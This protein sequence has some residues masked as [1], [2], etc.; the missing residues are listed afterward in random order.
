MATDRKSIFITGAASGIGRATA[1]LFAER[2]WFVGL[3]DA[4]PVTE[5]EKDIPAERRVSGGFD[6]R[7][8]A[9]WA[10]AIATFGQATGG[11]LDVLFNNAGIAR[12]GRFDVVPAAD[13]ALTVDVNLKGVLNGIYA[14]LPL[15]KATPGARIINTASAASLY[16]TPRSAVYS[17]TKFAVRG[18]SQALDLE[19]RDYGVRCIAIA[20]WFID[21][22]LLDTPS[23][24]TNRAV[25]EVISGRMKVYPV[26]IVAEGVWRAA[27]GD[28]AF[29]PIGDAAKELDFAARFFPGAVRRR[30]TRLVKGF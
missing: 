22:P 9:G 10:D 23:S 11:R 18:L 2:G 5:T 20:P 3:H 13:S 27:H 25:R 21:T 6:V 30:L 16:G 15:L 12:H 17:A 28:K 8:P 24:E 19:F 1:S 14:A 7:D 4:A 26:G 29:V